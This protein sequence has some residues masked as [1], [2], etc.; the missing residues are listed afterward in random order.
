MAS[1]CRINPLECLHNN[2]PVM[3]SWP[4]MTSQIKTYHQDPSNAS[5]DKLSTCQS[6]TVESPVGELLSC[7]RKRSPHAQVNSCLDHY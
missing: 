2:G 1:M 3:S 7:I 5:G 4:W 6:V